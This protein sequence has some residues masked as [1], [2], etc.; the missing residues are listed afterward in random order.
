MRT[1]GDDDTSANLFKKSANLT[2]EERQKFIVSIECAGASTAPSNIVEPQSPTGALD[3]H[4]GSAE[5]HCASSAMSCASDPN[6][7]DAALTA[8]QIADDNL[9]NS[10]YCTE[11]MHPPSHT[12]SATLHKSPSVSALAS[13]WTHAQ[14][15]MMSTRPAS[16]STPSTITSTRPSK[17][18]AEATCTTLGQSLAR[19]HEYRTKDK[20]PPQTLLQQH[21]QQT[22]PQ[23]APHLATQQATQQ[24]PAIHSHAERHVTASGMSQLTPHKHARVEI[25]SA[26]SPPDAFG[27]NVNSPTSSANYYTSSGADSANEWT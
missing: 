23:R 27:H 15:P 19:S 11:E 21:K 1:G 6:S 14:R 4:S 7:P 25:T 12:Q 8:T 13:S 10:L 26:E 16:T 18:R 20:P 24:A 22:V 2:H 9:T 5:T 17:P 3:A